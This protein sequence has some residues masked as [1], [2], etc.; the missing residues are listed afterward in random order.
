VTARTEPVKKRSDRPDA[1]VAELRKSPL[2]IIDPFTRKARDTR[3]VI[4]TT[5]PISPFAG[6]LGASRIYKR[7]TAN[8]DPTRDERGAGSTKLQEVDQRREAQ[9]TLRSPIA[10]SSRLRSG[11][12][13]RVGPG[14]FSHDRKSAAV[15]LVKWVGKSKITLSSFL[16]LRV[17]DLYWRQLC[18]FTFTQFVGTRQIFLD[19][20]FGITILS[21]L[22][23][24]FTMTDRTMGRPKF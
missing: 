1:R 8:F 14:P 22:V 3:F 15:K 17:A 4:Q 6:L 2:F 13:S 24:S 21:S 5:G 10:N 20:S 12:F 9:N 18:R 23:I 7:T 11:V 16:H 19:F